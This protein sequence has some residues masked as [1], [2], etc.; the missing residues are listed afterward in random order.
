MLALRSERI[1]SIAVECGSPISRAA[2]GGEGTRG[3]LGERGS[4]AT[5]VEEGVG[6]WPMSKLGK[7]SVD[8]TEI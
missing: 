4:V 8:A 5:V 1:A 7:H 2:E 6:G 3:G